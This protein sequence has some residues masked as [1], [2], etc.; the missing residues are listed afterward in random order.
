MA[1][2]MKNSSMKTAPNGSTP[3]I[4]VLKEKTHVLIHTNKN[5]YKNACQKIMA[6]N[7]L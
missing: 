6:Q 1:V 3:A 5:V 7:T 2:K 4:I